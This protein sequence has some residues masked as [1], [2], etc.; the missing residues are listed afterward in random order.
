MCRAWV[1]RFGTVTRSAAEADVRIGQR[2]IGCHLVSESE[3][4]AR[5]WRV[6]LVSY[7]QHWLVTLAD[8]SAVDVWADSAEGLSGPEDRRDYL[9]G[10]LMDI[11]PADQHA[12][13]VTATTPANLDRVVVA[14]ARFPRTSVLRVSSA[15]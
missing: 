2:G 6:N 8:G 10:N 15:S 9:F 3:Y 4:A 5:L 13:D 7:P 1:R 14:V 11:A 12:F